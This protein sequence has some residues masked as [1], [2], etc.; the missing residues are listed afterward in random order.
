M[1]G[2]GFSGNEHWTGSLIPTAPGEIS[3]RIGVLIAS[4][5]LHRFPSGEMQH[6]GPGQAFHARVAG[7]RVLVGDIFNHDGKAAV[8]LSAELGGEAE[9]RLRALDSNHRWHDSRTVAGSSSGDLL[10]ETRAF[11]GLR[12][13]EVVELALWTRPAHWVVFNDVSLAA[14]HETAPTISLGPAPDPV[15]SATAASSGDDFDRGGVLV[16]GRGPGLPETAGKA[17]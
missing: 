5:P 15:A 13:A 4:G 14:G 17:W 12:P 8:Q 16:N 11:D 9:W 2:D 1:G 7:R 6:R 3:A 10:Q